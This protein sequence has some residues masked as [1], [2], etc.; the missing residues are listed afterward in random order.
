MLSDTLTTNE[1]KNA[2]GAEVEFL[3]SS[4]EGRK[5][6]WYASSVTNPQL[7][8]LLTIQHSESGTGVNKVRR[9]NI[10]VDISAAGVSTAVR[11]STAS[12]TLSIPIG[13]ISSLATVKDALAELGS[14]VHTLASST[15]LYDGTGNGAAALVAGTT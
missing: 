8:H 1:V 4:Q 11:T 14:L 6:I 12:L 9:S 15:H 3:V 5:K 2:A 7:P 13:D 10:R